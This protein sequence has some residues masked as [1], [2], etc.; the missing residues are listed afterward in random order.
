MTFLP[1]LLLAAALDTASP[2][3]HP[4]CFKVSYISAQGITPDGTLELSDS[5]ARFVNPPPDH[6]QVLAYLRDEQAGYESAWWKEVEGGIVIQFVHDGVDGARLM[7]G[8]DGR[9]F[10][11]ITIPS[12][13]ATASAMPVKTILQPSLCSP[14]FP[15]Q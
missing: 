13:E 4:E 11:G 3:P 7:L 9:G 2:E 5:A 12:P 8:H 10:H 1:I 14:K 6:H 15:V